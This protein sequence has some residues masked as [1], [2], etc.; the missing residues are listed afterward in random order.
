MDAFPPPQGRPTP[1]LV[2]ALKRLTGSGKDEQ[3]TGKDKGK[4]PVIPRPTRPPKPVGPVDYGPMVRIPA[5]RFLMGSPEEENGESNE[6]PQHEVIITRTFELG[7]TP[8]TQAQDEAVM[9][10]IPASVKTW[11]RLRGA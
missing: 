1:E 2:N 4:P 7:A 6:R 10:R 3:K 5:G 9:G 11:E 8:V